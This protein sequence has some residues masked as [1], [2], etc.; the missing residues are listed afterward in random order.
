MV[1]WLL[2]EATFGCCIPVARAEYFDGKRR[3]RGAVFGLERAQH[4]AV[5]HAVGNDVNFLSAPRRPP[6]PHLRTQPRGRARAGRGGRPQG[7]GGGGD[8]LGALYFCFDV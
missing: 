4:E 8:T 7:R 6:P 2:S 1:H 3:A 5:Q